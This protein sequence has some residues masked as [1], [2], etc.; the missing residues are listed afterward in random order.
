I[1]MP[2]T[3]APGERALVPTGIRIAIPT[4]YEAQ[5][6]PRSGLALRWGVTL[7]NSPGTI[8]ADYRGEV[9]VI[10]VNLGKEPFTLHRGDRV[11]QLVFAPVARAELAEVTELDETERGEGGFGHTGVGPP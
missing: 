9:Q 5:V 7:L 2:L 3:L 10:L 4:G 8:D 11:A 6:R 1:S